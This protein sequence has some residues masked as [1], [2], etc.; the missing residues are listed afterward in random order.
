[1]K[2]LFALLLAFATALTL[3]ACA[4]APEP[5]ASRSAPEASDNGE[6]EFTF[7][8]VRPSATEKYL[9]TSLGIE[10]K[11]VNL[12][13]VR[14]DRHLIDAEIETAMQYGKTKAE[15]MA[16]TGS[17]F[18]ELQRKQ[19][20]DAATIKNLRTLFPE[21]PY[22]VLLNWTFDDYEAYSYAKTYESMRPSEEILA[23][24]ERRGITED[25]FV[26]LR[27]FYEYESDEEIIAKSDDELRATII[28]DYEQKLEYARA[29]SNDDYGD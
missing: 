1:M 2:K 7:V 14:D 13:A 25:D 4:K 18:K 19:K 24:L 17:E 16:M 23:E 5:A 10:M 6:P 22:S 12:Q 28:K 9:P 3:F 21:V 20:L 8:D 15:A 26:R 11:N 29:V 27:K